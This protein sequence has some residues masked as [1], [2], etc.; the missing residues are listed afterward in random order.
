MSNGH[1]RAFPAKV[2]IGLLISALAAGACQPAF[3]GASKSVNVSAASSLQA[4]YAALAKKF[5]ATH[6]GIK[7]N[8]SFGSSATLAYQIS[9]GAPVDI[10]VSADQASMTIAKSEIPNP[11]NYVVNQVVLAVPINSTITKI[12][13]LTRDVKW[14]QCVNTAPCGIAAERALA[15]E[16]ELRSDPVSYEA[17]AST[18]LGKLLA[19]VVDAAI[20]YKTDVIANR[21]KLRA[22]EFTNT[23]AASTQYQIG[24]SKNAMTKKNRW[25]TTFFLYLNSSKIRKELIKAGFQVDSLT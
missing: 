1:L 13:S 19:G 16:G 17:S 9:A 21:A 8:I 24:I 4:Q 10:F 23:Q 20:I 14:I 12:E 25:A 3:A 2:T 15:A 7:I 6:P 18:V 5:E 11:K 22:I